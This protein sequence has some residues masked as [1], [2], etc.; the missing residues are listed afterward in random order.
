MNNVK[1]NYF[2]PSSLFPYELSL[3]HVRIIRISLPRRK[4]ERA[5]EVHLGPSSSI[6]ATLAELLGA[7]IYPTTVTI[8]LPTDGCERPSSL[9]GIEKSHGLAI[10]R[11]MAMNVRKDNSLSN[12]MI[13]LSGSSDTCIHH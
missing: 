6:E 4:H 9:L 10:N 13:R 2:P 7:F 3:V 1:C 5:L 8:R 12:R 11:G